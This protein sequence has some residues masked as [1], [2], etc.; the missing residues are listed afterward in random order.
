M[1]I[2]RRNFMGVLLSSTL[3][4]LFADNCRPQIAPPF[5]KVNLTDSPIAIVYHESGS[6]TF[7]KGRASSVRLI[8]PDYTNIIPL[9]KTKHNKKEFYDWILKRGNVPKDSKPVFYEVIYC[10]LSNLYCEY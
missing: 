8:G 6:R 4:P 3:T 1:E 10:D 2:N 7:E 9:A 5:I